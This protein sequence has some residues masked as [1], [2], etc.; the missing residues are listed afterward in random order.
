MGYKLM[1][2]WDVKPGHDQQYFEFIVREWVP[3]ISKLGLEPREMWYTAYGGGAQIN[4]SAT[5]EDLPTMRDILES[6][7][8]ADLHASLLEHVEGYTHKVVRALPHF[9]V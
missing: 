6:E 1:M 7:E 2:S 8:W 4:T 3:G 9:Q 5:T